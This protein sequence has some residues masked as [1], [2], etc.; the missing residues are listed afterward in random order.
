[1][2]PSIHNLLRSDLA[3]FA[4]YTPIVPLEVLAQQLGLTRDQL[5]KLDANENPYGPTAATRAALAQLATPTGAQEVVALYPDPDNTALRTA[6]AEHLN[7][8]MARIICGNGSDELIDLLLRA[9]V[10]PGRTVVDATPT[11]GMYAFGAHLYQANLV[12]VPRTATFDLDI[13]ALRHAI[14]THQAVIVFLAAPNN[15]TGNPL[16]RA[17]LLAI[18]EL[19]LVVVA[20]EAYAEFSGETFIDLIDA[21]PNLVVLRT[22]SKWAGLA[23]L[24]IGYGVMHE[25]MA[26]ELRKIK[27]PYT[28]NVAAEVAA[29]AAIRDFASMQPIIEQI[30]VERERLV[31]ALHALDCQVYPS[32]ANFVLVRPPVAARALRDELRRQGVLIRYFAK[33]RL[34]DLMRI[35]IGTPHQHERLL[36]VLAHS[37]TLIKSQG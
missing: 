25:S 7:Q 24:R 26:D 16:R 34:S 10:T 23:G 33:E 28:V 6:I 13:D 27:Q 17:D 20:D 31:A 11:F 12:E 19:P 3:G 32:T 9:T 29:T 21:H 37:I 2:A 15:P 22:L 1:M 5:I 8:P 14:T 18:L 4:P 35:S 30:K 36:E